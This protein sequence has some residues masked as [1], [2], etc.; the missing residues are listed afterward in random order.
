[1]EQEEKGE[2]SLGWRW[3]VGRFVGG[4][5]LLVDL[6][7]RVEKEGGRGF[8][9]RLSVGVG[10]DVIRSYHEQFRW[11]WSRALETQTIPHS[12]KSH[13]TRYIHHRNGSTVNYGG[14]FLVL[15]A[16]LV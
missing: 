4:W 1:M 15:S 2:W 16:S 6:F 9:S 3:F 13:M 14:V 7:V 5:A 11:I 10:L 8:A 12:T